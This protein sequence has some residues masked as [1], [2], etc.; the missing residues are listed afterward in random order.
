LLK[1]TKVI[2]QFQNHLIIKLNDSETDHSTINNFNY[3]ANLPETTEIIRGIKLTYLEEKACD[4]KNSSVLNSEVCLELNCQGSK[5][6]SPSGR[7]QLWAQQVVATDLAQKYLADQKIPRL[8]RIAVI[9]SG[10]NIKLQKHIIALKKFQI[11]PAINSASG[12]TTDSMGHGTRV[13]SLIKGADGIGGSTES[14]L[15]I[16]GFGKDNISSAELNNA[17]LKAC[18]DNNQIINISM[19]FVQLPFLQLS[20]LRK[21]DKTTLNLI[22][23][24]GC[25]I[26]SAAGNNGIQHMS[27]AKKSP[28]D[29]SIGAIDPYGKI[30]DFSNASL[31]QAPGQSVIGLNGDRD[32]F[33]NNDNCNNTFNT[34]ASGTSFAAPLFTDILALTRDMLMSSKIFQNLDKPEQIVI[35]TDIIKNSL[36][37]KTANAYLAVRLADS[38][39]KNPKLSIEELKLKLKTDL[40]NNCSDDPSECGTTNMSCNQETKCIDQRRSLS[41]VCQ[42]LALDQ[43]TKLISTLQKQGD[44]EGALYWIQAITEQFPNKKINIPF[45]ISKLNSEL[46]SSSSQSAVTRWVSYYSY[47]RQISDAPSPETH[48]YLG[49]IARNSIIN[50]DNLNGRELSP[51][52]HID[53]TQLFLSMKKSGFTQPETILNWVDK[54]RNNNEN[55]RT[56]YMEALLKGEKQG[57]VSPDEISKVIQNL[58]STTASISDLDNATIILTQ[59]TSLDSKSKIKFTDVILNSTTSQDKII[60]RLLPLKFSTIDLHEVIDFANEFIEKKKIGS[61]SA[62]SIISYLYLKKD[63]LSAEDKENMVLLAKKLSAISSKNSIS[64]QLILE[65]ISSMN[66]K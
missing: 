22:K 38:W 45:P 11:K 35:L 51:T 28:F 56:F 27:H 33:D 31:F 36:I 62:D 34:F 7:T 44:L 39:V 53:S 60:N 29:F 63:E 23:N 40:N 54:L 41:I 49:Q 47:W 14:N 2:D 64:N 52:A 50:M 18:S 19:A 32:Y 43:E 15:T 46:N 12:F 66:K 8:T 9:D 3:Y 48:D 65:I 58:S 21:F 37:G 10:F 61:L 59:S 16:Y 20:L 13:T 25:I 30:T 4:L 17:V 26:V 57:L 42:N 6:C 1:D 5:F 24:K 55:K